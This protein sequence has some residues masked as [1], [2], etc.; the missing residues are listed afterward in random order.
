MELMATKGNKILQNVKIRWISMLNPTKKVMVRY[1]T[2]LVKMTLD[3]L[4]NQQ[5]MN[6]FVTSILFLDLLTF[7]PY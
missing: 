7:C 1:K 4:I 2:L 6:T 3:N 5:V